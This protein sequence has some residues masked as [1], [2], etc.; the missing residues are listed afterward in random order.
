MKKFLTVLLALSVVFT[1]SFSAVGTAF[2][3]TDAE[4]NGNVNAALERVQGNIDRAYESALKSIKETTTSGFVIS[5]DSWKAVASEYRDAQK[6]LAGARAEEIK[7]KAALKDSTE[8]ELIALFVETKG[9]TNSFVGE[10]PI[11]DAVEF[12]RGM[13]ADTDLQKK[14]AAVEFNTIKANAIKNLESVNLTV[15]STDEKEIAGEK[16][17]YR[18]IAKKVIDDA[19][20]AIKAI[21]IAEGAEPAAVKTEADKIG[22]AGKSAYKEASGTEQVA[23]AGTGKLADI[24]V[25]RDAEGKETAV[26]QISAATVATKQL[27][28]IDQEAG[29]A[30]TLE[31]AKSAAL[32]QVE[33]KISTYLASKVTK[34]SEEVAAAQKLAAAYKTAQTYRINAATTAASIADPKAIVDTDKYVANVAAIEEIE[35]TAAKYK[36]ALDEN[37]AAAYDA[38]AIDRIVKDAKDAAY[39]NDGTAY[40]G[41]D[42]AITAIKAAKATPAGVL[43][44][45]KVAKAKYEIEAARDAKLYSA[46]GEDLFYAPEK[47]E[48]EKLY[49]ALL[50]ELEKVTKDAEITTITNKLPATGTKADA[51]DDK[52][53]VDGKV[54]VE[55]SADWA[56]L[57]KYMTYL[58]GSG[59]KVIKFD[60]QGYTQDYFATFYAENGVRVKADITEALYAK[61]EAELRKAKTVGEVKADKEAVEK[62]I[63]ALPAKVTIA[64]KAAVEAIWEAL[65]AYN[66]AA[67]KTLANTDIANINTYSLA[68]KA[69]ADAEKEVVTDTFKKLPTTATVTSAD[70]AAVKAAKEAAEEFNAKVDSG[71]IYG[72]TGVVAYTDSVTDDLLTEIQK[73]EKNAVLNAIEKLPLNITLAN[74][75]DVEAA[76]ALYD[77][78]VAEYTDFET[79]KDARTDI[80][81]KQELFDAEAAIKALEKSD[82]EARIQAVKSFKIKTTTKRYTGSKMRVN[83]TVVEGNES[84]IDGYRIYYSTKKSNSGYKY[85]AKTTKKYINHTSIKKSVKKGTRVYYRVRA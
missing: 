16:T 1:Y 85:L 37:G 15:Y 30:L 77:A 2:A 34:P 82:A 48:V 51:I 11:T 63:S 8:A 73:L 80:T 78:Y 55:M 39:N 46:N 14:A 29:E 44:A 45:Y 43:D 24:E 50:A 6:T 19:V 25:V 61:A 81:N 72:S 84:A 62:M 18:A 69:V 65:T 23:V 21:V 49:D 42:D 47:A 31:A 3:A 53:E 38:D 56:R 35:K 58:S 71:E 79:S 57:E 40:S 4:F 13:Q 67:G 5:A 33:A 36:A 74:K 41:K 64:D 59:D 76:R 70:K 83:W 22:T 17:S 54:K 9:G 12:I 26:Y 66:K 28:T 68:L 52:S 75:A 7:G 10:A 27:K 32:A 20:A 60:N